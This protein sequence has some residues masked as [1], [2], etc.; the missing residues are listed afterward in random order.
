MMHMHVAHF[1]L[2]FLQP[3]ITEEGCWV[4]LDYE[5]KHIWPASHD[6][7]DSLQGALNDLRYECPCLRLPYRAV[8]ITSACYL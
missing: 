6:T 1:A 5:L 4:T 2:D 8:H 3:N 7:M